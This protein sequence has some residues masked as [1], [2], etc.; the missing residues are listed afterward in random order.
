LRYRAEIDGL[1]AVAV[2]PV[3][4]FHAGF[5]LFKGGF[6][7]VDIFFVISGYLITSIILSEL[8]EGKFSLVKFYERRARRILP[9]LFFVMAACIPF[10]WMWLTPADVV[11]FSKS[12]F[13]VATFSSNILF[14]QETGYF[15]PAAELKPLLHTWSLAVEEQ[16]YILFPLFLMAIWRFGTRWIL[17]IFVV[18]GLVSL[19]ISEW[20]AHND[21]TAAFYLLPTRGW[22]ILIGAFV[23]FYFYYSG[24]TLL[25][26]AANQA[27]SFTGLLL[28]FYSIFIF[29]GQTPFP[30]L[31]TLVPTAGAAFLILCAQQGT[32]AQRI[33]SNR[34]MVGIGL[35]SYSAYLW[36]QPLFAF[37]KQRS[38]TTPSLSMMAF[39]CVLTLLLAYFSW[40][41]V[42]RPF[43]QRERITRTVIFSGAA[44][45]ASVF[46]IVGLL[47]VVFGGFGTRFAN[48]LQL[49]EL[50]KMLEGNRGLS[51]VCDRTYT[52]SDECVFGSPPVA[53]LWG[54]SFAMHLAQ[55]LQ[56]SS[57]G[58]AF[59]QHTVSSCRPLLGMSIIGGG[60]PRSWAEHC[61]DQN[62]KVFEWLRAHPTVQY[63]V[64]SSPFIFS[65]NRVLQGGVIKDY[66]PE[67]IKNSFVETVEK[68]K[69]IG[70]KVVIMSPPPNNGENIGDCIS[71]AARFGV[72]PSKCDFDIASFS[73][74]TREG[75]KFLK[76]IQDIVPII[77]LDELI[78][79]N[80]VCKVTEDGLPIYRDTQH[81]SKAGSS[82]LG[83]KFNLNRMIIEGAS[84]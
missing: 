75:Y 37:A 52:E 20:G 46:V 74:P 66:D 26:S 11:S 16:Y 72:S 21:P 9:V 45:L 39:L 82:L 67:I 55:A 23:A 63:V 42:E 58:L 7:G 61:I 17:G 6:V 36:H 19:G 30:S 33:L 49:G 25:S 83:R 32:I 29:D 78:C 68:L 14:W 53:L 31:F 47:G 69:A 44:G 65:D 27:L 2:I 54:D 51:Q 18:I 56:S 84:S 28:V 4:F 71:K 24:G 76:S 40:R 13:A 12:L 3:I 48:G 60:F 22:E 1:R 81:L 43:R 35:L 79:I 59:R 62:D 10:A 15:N 8:S 73:G 77:W 64:V 80:G 70:K 34:L 41:F 50:D 57:T 5:K 38:L